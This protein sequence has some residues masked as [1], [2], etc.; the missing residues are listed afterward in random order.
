MALMNARYKG[1]CSKC[2]GFMNIGTLIDYDRATRT[3]KHETCPEK[4]VT[5]TL[6]DA[7]P[8]VQEL[9]AAE[10]RI[11]TLSLERTTLVVNLG[12]Q[13]RA[14]FLALGGCPRCNGTRSVCTWSTL[15]SLSGAFDEF[16]PCPDCKDQPEKPVGYVYNRGARYH[17]AG[18]SLR[19][20][21]NDYPFAA[22][23]YAVLTDELD[24]LTQRVRVLN[25]QLAIER[26]T[27][28]KVVKGRKVPK[29]TVGVVIWTGSGQFGPR[30]GIKDAEGTTHWTALSNV[31]PS[32]VRIAA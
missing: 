28:V 22:V 9:D 6:V 31:A 10:A 26:G 4:P 5:L 11:R 13:A 29:G 14:E 18:R 7:A 21:L 30:V 16:G 27:E 24:T 1:K 3:A 8:L 17:N 25:D 12:A 20:P 2:G 32:K 15:D 19:D 23:A